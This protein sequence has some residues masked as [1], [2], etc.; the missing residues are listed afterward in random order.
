MSQTK[1]SENPIK[2]PVKKAKRQFAELAPIDPQKLEQ[3]RSEVQ[4]VINN[5]CDLLNS[6][7]VNPR[8][9]VEQ[10]AWM[11]FLKAFDEAEAGRADLAVFE[12]TVVQERLKNE[13]R[14]SEWSKLT[15]RPDELLKFVNDKLWPKLLTL[16]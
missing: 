4:Q 5:A 10:I 7:G 13:Y 9:Y 8:D 2:T 14:W 1:T 3:R 11:F 12:G 15:D 6:A 16:G